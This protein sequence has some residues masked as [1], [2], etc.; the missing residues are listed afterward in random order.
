MAAT[1]D[2]QVRYVSPQNPPSLSCVLVDPTQTQVA[3]GG[4]GAVVGVAATS[5]GDEETGGHSVALAGVVDVV[6][7][8]GVVAAVVADGGR[9]SCCQYSSAAL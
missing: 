5:L 2:L 3:S 8:S 4:G 1:Q 9:L 7:A 6:E